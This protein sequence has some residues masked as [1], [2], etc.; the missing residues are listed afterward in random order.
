LLTVEWIL[1][2]VL[3]K[4]QSIVVHVVFFVDLTCDRFRL[5]I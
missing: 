1:A 5:R 2:V 3:P 4:K